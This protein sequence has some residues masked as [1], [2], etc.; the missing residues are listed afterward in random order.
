MRRFFILTVFLTARLAFADNPCAQHLETVRTHIWSPA[1]QVLDLAQAR[2]SVANSEIL[3][4]LELLLNGRDF[5]NNPT[6]TL[7]MYRLA[8]AAFLNDKLTVV[9]HRP[10]PLVVDPEANLVSFQI[11]FSPKVIFSDWKQPANTPSRIELLE[12]PT[13][14]ILSQQNEANSSAIL[15]LSSKKNEIAVVR[16]IP[17]LAHIRWDQG[18]LPAPVIPWPLGPAQLQAL[19]NGVEQN[20]WLVVPIEN[21]TVEQKFWRV[22]TALTA[23]RVE[24]A[25]QQ[26]QIETVVFGETALEQRASAA[27]QLL[28][29]RVA[30]ISSLKFRAMTSADS[31]LEAE[32]RDWVE[33]H[34]DALAS[35]N[36]PL[37]IRALLKN[38]SDFK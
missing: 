13:L 11:Y 1:G 30:G 33:Q 17:R 8:D 10:A 3:D 38:V 23:A 36:Q 31:Q 32:M 29:A 37:Q 25:S 12:H 28:A 2:T 22:L 27:I 21:A 5:A 26:L 18:A 9:E 6:L 7:Q 16:N 20:H 19:D 4:A 14:A 34:L 35:Q 24:V 15:Q